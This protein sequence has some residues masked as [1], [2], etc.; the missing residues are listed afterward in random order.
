MIIAVKKIRDIVGIVYIN[1]TLDLIFEV[2]KNMNE[3]SRSSSQ[4]GN[5][6]L[7]RDIL[8]ELDNLNLGVT[9]KAEI[10]TFLE[11]KKE[12]IKRDIAKDSKFPDPFL[13][14]L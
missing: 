1:M 6:S 10:R 5:L 13:D 7:L 14:K 3:M 8:M 9:S 2:A 12:E 11:N 4:Y